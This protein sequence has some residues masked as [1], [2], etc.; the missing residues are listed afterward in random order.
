MKAIISLGTFLRT[1]ALTVVLGFSSTLVAQGW[2]ALNIPYAVSLNDMSSRDANRLVFAG[3]KGA[4]I[5]TFDGGASFDSIPSGTSRNISSVSCTPDYCFALIGDSILVSSDF[6]DWTKYKLPSIGGTQLYFFENRIGYISAGKA[7]E[8]LKSTNGGLSWEVLSTN[9]PQTVLN[10]VIFIS[11]TEGFA[12]SHAFDKTTRKA[13]GSILKTMDGGLTWTIIKTVPQHYLSELVFTSSGT[14]YAVGQAGL[15]M[16]STDGG[17]NW[18]QLNAGVSF[19]INNI[20]FVD[21]NVGYLSGAMGTVL[22]TMD[23]GN[24]WTALDTGKTYFFGAQSVLDINTL[25]LMVAANV[26]LKTQTGGI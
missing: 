10:S 23:R 9:L 1:A 7:G 26:L 24:T 3:D 16:T 8:L 12:L 14:A 11:E 19:D 17:S 15:L 20:S 2:E 6:R 21:N 22:K 4:I 13:D 18:T 5:A 25:Y